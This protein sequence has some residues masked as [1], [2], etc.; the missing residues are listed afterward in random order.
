MDAEDVVYVVAQ[1]TVI[2]ERPWND[3][4]LYTTTEWIFDEPTVYD[5]A[6]FDRI[7]PPTVT[8]NRAI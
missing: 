5:T 2:H 4:S 1:V 6:E 8:E 3:D 7:Y